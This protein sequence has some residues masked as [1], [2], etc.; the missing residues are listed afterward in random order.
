MRTGHLHNRA[1][2]VDTY[3]LTDD[4]LIQEAGGRSPGVW[5]RTAV[6]RLA[7]ADPGLSQL[8]LGLQS[9][10]GIVVAVGLVDLFVHVTGALQLRPGSAPAP[11][12]IE[13]APIAS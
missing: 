4:V 9:V 7:G 2:T 5:W 11:V 12:Y 10:L 3:G 8:R 6:D 13:R 1:S